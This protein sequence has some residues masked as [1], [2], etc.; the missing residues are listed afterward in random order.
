MD[1]I[2]WGVTSIFIISV[3]ICMIEAVIGDSIFDRVVSIDAL[4]SITIAILGLIAAVNEAA[5]FIDVAL[6]YALIAFIGTLAV[7]KYQEGRDIGE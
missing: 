2:L 7:S 4:T 5:I 6:V 3:V 1:Q